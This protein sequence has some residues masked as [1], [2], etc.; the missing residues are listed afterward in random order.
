VLAARTGMREF[1][2]RAC[3]MRSEL[4]GRSSLDS[5]AALVAEVENPVLRERV[6]GLRAPIGA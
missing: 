4:G 6:Q 3:L 5:A 2:V 1:G